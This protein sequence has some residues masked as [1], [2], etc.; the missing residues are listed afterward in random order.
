MH[1]RTFSPG[2]VVALEGDP[3]QAVLVLHGLLRTRRLSLNG[4]EQVLAYWARLVA[5]LSRRWMTPNLATP[6]R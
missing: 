2:H 4:R 6:M 5:N 3:C 1:E